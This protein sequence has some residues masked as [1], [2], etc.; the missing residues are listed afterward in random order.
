MDHVFWVVIVWHFAIHKISAKDTLNRVCR[1]QIESENKI[2][3][4]PSNFSHGTK[5][6]RA[7]CVRVLWTSK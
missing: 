4:R 2:P 7:W 6:K 1:H 3:N 5:R